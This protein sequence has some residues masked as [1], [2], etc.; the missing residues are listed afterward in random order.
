MSSSNAV[1]LQTLRKNGQNLPQYNKRSEV[2]QRNSTTQ[3]YTQGI[4]KCIHAV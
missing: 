4:Y 3:E 2:I 1:K